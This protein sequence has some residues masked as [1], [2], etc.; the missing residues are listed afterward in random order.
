MNSTRLAAAAL[1]ALGL[2]LQVA[3]VAPAA[4]GQQPGVLLAQAESFG[5]Q[6]LQSFAMAAIEVGKIRDDYVA[7]IQQT[8]DGE[9]RKRL[10]R[11][12]NSKM[13]SAVRA[14]PGISVEEYN[15]ISQA[16]SEDA[17]LTDKINGMIEAAGQ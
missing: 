4:A 2:V 3:A 8:D 6:K 7:R 1:T 11:E 9:E 10:A 16:A 17:A 15:A 13:I 5:E 14:A 12:A